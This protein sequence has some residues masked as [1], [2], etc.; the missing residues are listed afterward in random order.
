MALPWT[1]LG[2]RAGAMTLGYAAFDDG[3]AP[4]VVTFC[5]VQPCTQQEPPHEGRYRLRRKWKQKSSL[6]TEQRSAKL[7]KPQQL[8]SQENLRTGAT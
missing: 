6:S 4:L 2:Q 5:E 7:E 1:S 3:S 8:K